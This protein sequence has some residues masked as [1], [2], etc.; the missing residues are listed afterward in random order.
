MLFRSPREMKA[1]ERLLR[2]LLRHPDQAES[3]RDRLPENYLLSEGDR[4]LYRALLQR[5]LAGRELTITAL[6]EMLP[7]Q[8]VDRVAKWQLP[9]EPPVSEQEAEDCLRCLQRYAAQISREEL[10]QL[11][12]EALKQYIAALNR[13]KNRRGE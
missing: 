9:G 10:G 7:P 6:G 2:Y 13:E 12:G 3:L 11:S 4:T 1:A 8:A 5:G